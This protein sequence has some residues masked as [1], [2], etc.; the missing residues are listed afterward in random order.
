MSSPARW[1]APHF[2]WAVRDELADKLCGVG[3]PSCDALDLG[4]LRVTTTLDVGL[5][6]TAEKWVAAAAIVPNKKDMTAAAEAM[7]LCHR[8]FKGAGHHFLIS[9]YCHPQ[10]IDILRT[11]AARLGC[12]VWCVDTKIFVKE[13]DYQSSGL[14]LSVDKEGTL[15]GFT[16]RMNSSAVVKK[17]TVKGWNPETKKAD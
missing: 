14:K 9:K 6:K 4:G 13:P 7:T 2:V 11:R 3:V 10:T 16:P 12:H 1:I 8:N 17:V 5:Q 15:R